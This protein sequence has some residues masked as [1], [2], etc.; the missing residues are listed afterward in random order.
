MLN[1]EYNYV[2][3]QLYMH[4]YPLLE[5]G[6]RTGLRTIAL[7]R[8]DTE[9]L[10]ECSYQYTKLICIITIIDILLVVLLIIDVLGKQNNHCCEL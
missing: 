8:K 3:V 4:Y 10:F 6:T 2:Q 9:R 1:A 5:S 7:C